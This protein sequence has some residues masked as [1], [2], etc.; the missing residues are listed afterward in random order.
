MKQS[1]WIFFTYFN[2]H[3]VRAYLT[4]SSN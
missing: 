3:C 1:P 4:R 2:N